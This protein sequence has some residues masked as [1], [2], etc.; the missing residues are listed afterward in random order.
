MLEFSM[1][2]TRFPTCFEESLRLL[3]RGKR[4]RQVVIAKAANPNYMHP[5]FKE[6]NVTCLFQLYVCFSERPSLFLLGHRVLWSG[7]C[8]RSLAA[9]RYSV[10]AL[11]ALI[12]SR[13][14]KDSKGQSTSVVSPPVTRLLK[15]LLEQLSIRIHRRST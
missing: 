5:A 2:R 12:P 4:C 3:S 13:T 14:L 9:Q 15:V 8:P 6:V 7:C 10:L 1:R 11:F